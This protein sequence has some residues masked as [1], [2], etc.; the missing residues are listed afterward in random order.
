M[1]LGRGY[2][3]PNY[4]NVNYPIPYDPPF[5]PDE[6]PC[7]LYSR[8]FT[9]PAAMAGKKIYLNFEGVDSAFYVW[10]NDEFAAYSQVSHMTSE[11]DHNLPRSCG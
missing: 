9:V 2:D 11:I 6:N 4:T 1:A 7:G 3:V 8:K 10:V 5:V